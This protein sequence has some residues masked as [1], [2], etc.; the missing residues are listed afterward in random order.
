MAKLVETSPTFTVALDAMGGDYGPEET[1]AGGVQ[2]AREQGV[3]VVLVGDETKVHEELAKL[4]FDGL[5]V[6]VKASHGI[7]EET[8][9]PLQAI[10]EK[11]TASIV[12]ATKLVRTGR[13]QAVVSMGSTGGAMAT[14][15]LILGLVEGMERPALGGPILGQ[16]SSAVILDLGSNVDCRPS[17]L[18]GF[19]AIGTAFARKIQH[20][21][22]PRIALLSVGAEEGK[23]NRQVREAYSL[24]QENLQNFVGNIEGVDIFHD[25]ADVIVCDGFVGNILLK[26]V[27]GLGMKLMASLPALLESVMP[28]ESIV[29]LGEGLLSGTNVAETL[30]GAPLFGVKG[31]SI[32]GHGRSRAPNIASAVHMAKRV[33]DSGMNEAVEK[34]LS[35]LHQKVANP[36]G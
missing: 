26:F 19:A 8:D 9:H 10:R 12:E 27:E 25:K 4:Q 30:G 22:N 11:P 18:L 36:Y 21:E 23:G 14:S 15:A 1:V 32:V 7:I 24:F 17:Q 5:P 33:W 6:Y 28:R 34:E 3:G 13:T 20:I 29:K 2:A 31:V 35:A 16:L